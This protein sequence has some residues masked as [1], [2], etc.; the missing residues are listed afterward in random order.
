MYLRA[1]P[2]L[3]LYEDHAPIYDKGLLAYLGIAGTSQ[4]HL[5]A[6]DFE[7]LCISWFLLYP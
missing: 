1:F 5:Q 2:W 4:A 7:A 3:Q 6:C